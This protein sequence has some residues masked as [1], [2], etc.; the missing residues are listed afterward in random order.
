M[1]VALCP[2]LDLNGQIVL[3]RRQRTSRKPSESTR[4]IHCLIEIQDHLPVYRHVRIQKS[5]CA[6][7]L[8]QVR[9]IAE[10]DEK[11]VLPLIQWLKR[12]FFSFEGEFQNARTLH[13]EIPAQNIWNLDLLRLGKSFKPRHD[14]VAL[15]DRKPLQPFE[16]SFRFTVVVLQPNAES[17]LSLD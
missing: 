3:W 15:V 16:R 9:G 10:D 7:R 12:I 8:V 5:P 4:R 2:D 17:L 1:P 6:V 11:L 14:F 13:F